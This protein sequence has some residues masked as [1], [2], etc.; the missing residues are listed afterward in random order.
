MR[1][2]WRL[3]CGA[4]A[5]T[6]AL[7]GCGGSGGDGKQPQAFASQALFDPVPTISS[8]DAIVPFPFDGFFSGFTQPTLNIPNPDAI[9]FLSAANQVDGFSTVADGFADFTSFLDYSTV[10]AHLLIINTATGQ[11]LVYGTDFTIQ[12]SNATA[13]DPVTRQNTPISA[14]RS[15]ILIEWLKP[16]A[17]STRYLVAFTKGIRTLDGGGV[18]ASPEFSIVASSTP[19]SQQSSPEL[20]ALDATQRA[21]LETLR[22]QLIEPTVSAISTAT[23]IARDDIVLAWPFTTQSIG[24]SLAYVAAHVQADSG[25]FAYN[26]GVTT[27]TAVGVPGADIYAGTVTVPY[28]LKNSGGDPHSS[29]PLASYWLADPTQPDLSASFL[30]QVPCGAFV[31]PPPGSGFVPSTSTT[32]CFPAPVKQSDEKIPMLVTVPSGLPRPSNGWPVVIYQHGITG[33]R[34][35]ALAIAPAL[36]QA[37]FA[38]VAIDLPLHGLTDRSSPFYHNQLFANTPVSF[39]V[40]GERTFDLDLENNS[41]ASPCTAA[42]PDGQIDSSGAWFINLSSL[43]T[44]RDNLRQAEADLL[45]LRASLAD[46]D[47]DHDGT[48]DIDMANVRFASLSLGSIAGI[49]FLANDHVV[50]AASL[51][52]PGGGIAKLLDASKSIGPQISAGLACPPPAGGGLVEGSDDYESFIRFAQNIVDDGDPL[53]FAAASAA[54]HPIHL[55]EVVGGGDNGAGGTFPADT[56]VPNHALANSD[57]DNAS[58]DLVTVA[59][60][61]AGTNPLIA[62]MGLS[63]TGAIDVPVSTPS[64]VFTGAPLH[65]VVPFREGYHGSVLDPSVSP[66]ATVEM[67]TETVNFL[68]SDGLCL[69]LGGNCPR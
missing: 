17:P 54:A 25:I 63:S 21:T 66:A 27:A 8:D 30:G 1:S 37:G 43:L 33:N 61:N 64:V 51:A 48:P 24:K 29:A 44:A 60:F 50:G 46:L 41:A 10:P 19:V 65:Y 16:L 28:Y 47:L 67:Q 35:Q 53:N 20:T 52:V 14:Q 2:P 23:G 18:S 55:I 32:T 4:S 40:T 22:A 38:V 58:E 7:A 3:W 31:Q 42:G 68:A 36:A 26:T 13:P 62:A 12:T 9:S 49:P 15:R 5:L 57:P 6:V 69:P 56:V 59:S 34:T 45:R 11:P 39:L